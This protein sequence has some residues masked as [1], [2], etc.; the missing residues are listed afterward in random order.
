MK[1]AIDAGHGLHT[2]GRRCLKQFDANETREWTLN[3]RVVEEVSRHLTRCGVEVVRLDDPTGKQDVSLS[4]RSAKANREHCDFCVSIHHNAGINGGYGGGTVVYVYEGKH[5][6]KSDVLQ[7]NVY[8]GLI[9]AVGKF[10]NRSDPLA[11]KNLHMVRETRMPS[12]LV[13]VGFMDSLKDVPLITDPAWA[14]KAAMGIAKGICQTAG[15]RWVDKTAPAPAPAAK[16]AKAHLVRV[17]AGNLNV[18]TGP[19][20]KYRVTTQ[21]HKGEV[22]TIVG[23]A[24]NGP[25]LWGKLKSGAGWISLAYTEKV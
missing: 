8:D 12:V 25:T 11:V 1:I 18:R 23:Q 10:G 13:E 15:V 24:Y 17:T 20:T 19:G 16:P 2:P 4:A 9:G 5:S 7:K 3:A 6:A 21:V 14:A 22:F